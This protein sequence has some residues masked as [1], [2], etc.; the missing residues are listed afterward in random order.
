MAS[1]S[2]AHAGTRRRGDGG[3]G[4]PFGDQWT[5]RDWSHK[6]YFILFY[7]IG[8]GEE[9]D[10]FLHPAIAAGSAPPLPKHLE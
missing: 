4:D 10:A 5:F 9:E 2:A 3:F 8:W 7:F 1:I 6:V